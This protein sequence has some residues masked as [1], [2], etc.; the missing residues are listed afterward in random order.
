MRGRRVVV[1]DDDGLLREGIVSLLTLAGHDVVA[2]AGDAPT[3]RAAVRE[4]VPDVV[5]A[6]IR[7]PPSHTWE[8]LDVA[9]EIRAELPQV[10]ILL[11]SA[12][13]EV[14]TALDLLE[15]GD[16]IGYL[17]KSRVAK[18]SDLVDAVQRVSNGE[19]VIDTGLVREMLNARRRIGPPRRAHSA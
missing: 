8:G 11:L 15:S 3:L 2:Q 10:A 19:A 16:G 18:G 17:L 5:I 14:D 7:M 1:A 9:R 12:H 4:T 6:D 13:V